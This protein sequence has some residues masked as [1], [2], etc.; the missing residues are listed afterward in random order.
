MHYTCG[1]STK[2]QYEHLNIHICQWNVEWSRLVEEKDEGGGKWKKIKW[3]SRLGSESEE[4]SV[5]S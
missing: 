3:K 1:D 4:Y 2:S 5:P